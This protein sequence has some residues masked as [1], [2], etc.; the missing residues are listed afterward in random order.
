MASLQVRDVPEPL[1][2]KLSE[3]AKQE[4]RSIAQETI[5]LLAKGL[6]ITLNPKEKRK[7]IIAEIKENQKY[8]K[9]L[10]LSTP[11]KYLKEDRNR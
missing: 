4:H 11:L 5:V 3:L 8:L 2:N 6:N 10:N 1:Y 9:G 7:K